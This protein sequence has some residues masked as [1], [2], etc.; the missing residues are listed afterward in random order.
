[1]VRKMAVIQEDRTVQY[2]LV[3]LGS[4]RQDSLKALDRT[5]DD[6]GVVAW[7]DGHVFGGVVQRGSGTP[8]GAL[9]RRD[10]SFGDGLLEQGSVGK[11]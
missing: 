7:A 10:I 5:T 6:L 8:A 11:D 9:A 3:L 1:M 2:L 4:L